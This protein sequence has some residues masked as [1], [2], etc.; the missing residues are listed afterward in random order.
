MLIPK[1]K[2]GRGFTYSDF[3]QGS[4]QWV[5]NRVGKV[6]ASRL[7]DWL[8]VSKRPNKDGVHTPLKART[9]Y[10]MELKF[11]KQ[12]GVPF[13]K[14]V[15]KAMEEGIEAEDEVARQY[16]SITGN[17][18]ETCGSFYNDQ[19]VASPDRL[20]GE[21]GLLEIKWLYDTSFADVLENGVPH[22]YY[23]QMQGQLWSS[24]RKW[25][26]FV[27]GNGNT[28]KIKI[29]TVKREPEVIKQIK[30]SLEGLDKIVGTFDTTGLYDMNTAIEFEATGDIEGDPWA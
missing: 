22:M 28:G 29:I 18:V 26:D 17:K 14:F 20:V 10:E 13:S 1:I 9:D 11:E 27:V 15:T 7:T 4:P 2:A 6:T 19:F 5:M 8:A 16:A 3:P 21:D 23:L 24:G 30:E 25:C 12:F